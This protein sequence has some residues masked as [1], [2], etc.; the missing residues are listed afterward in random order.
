MRQLACLDHCVRHGLCELAGRGHNNS[1][2]D[3]GRMVRTRHHAVNVAQRV[4]VD[5][6]D[7]DRLLLVSMRD[8]LVAPKAQARARRTLYRRLDAGLGLG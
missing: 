7:R 5:A 3:V 8:R 2:V 1:R 6:S 4:A